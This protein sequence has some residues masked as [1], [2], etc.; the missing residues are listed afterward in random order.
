MERG[1]DWFFV[2][3]AKTA[4]DQLLLRPIYRLLLYFDREPLNMTVEPVCHVLSITI[5]N[6]QLT[7]FSIMSVLFWWFVYTLFI[8]HLWSLLMEVTLVNKNEENR[9]R[10][11]Q[12]G[13]YLVMDDF[14]IFS[15]RVTNFLYDRTVTKILQPCFYPP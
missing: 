8:C 6:M 7:A 4:K 9:N 10:S 11:V 3:V 12:F 2:K 1:R 15:L 14:R 5:S 13:F